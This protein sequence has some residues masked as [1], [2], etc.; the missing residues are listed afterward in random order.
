MLRTTSALTPQLSQGEPNEYVCLK[1]KTS[2][3]TIYFQR[4]RESSHG[5]ADRYGFFIVAPITVLVVSW[6]V[7]FGTS[8]DN[9][10]C[11]LANPP[12]EY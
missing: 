1:Y 11:C 4:I 3:E 6:Y 8:Q 7:Y 12:L 2:N 5:R 9:I 10:N